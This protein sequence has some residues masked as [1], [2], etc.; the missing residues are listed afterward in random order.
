[1]TGWILAVLAL[2]FIQTLLGPS[3]QYMM[4]GTKL[5]L[6]M[7]PRDAPPVVPAV[8]GRCNRAQSNMMEALLVFIP[9]ALL[10]VFK[11]ADSGLALT[12]AM[13]F[14]WARLVYL[15][16]YI[17]GIPGLRSLTWTIGHTGLGLMVWA[18]LA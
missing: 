8:A 11:G 16:A 4:G 9:V 2:F 14:F 5:R 13:V 3:L 12:G 1:M 10:L 7:G 18:L 15:P 17:S 6:A